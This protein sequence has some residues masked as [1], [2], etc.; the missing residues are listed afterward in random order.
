MRRRFLA[1]VCGP[2]VVV[3][4]GAVAVPA[5][6]QVPVSS[7]ATGTSE[8]AQAPASSQT[9]TQPPAQEAQPA[10]PKGPLAE[11]SRS[12]FAPSWNM[13]QL[14]GRVSSIS[15]DEARWQR[16]EDLGDGL[17]FTTGRLLRETPEWS[18]TAGADNVGW[19]DQRYFGNYERIG[20]LKVSGLWDQ[21]PQFY[22]IDTRTA[23]TS[24]G[25]GVLVLDDNAQR[26]ANLNTYL[27]ISP[28][29]DLREQRDIGTVRVGATPTTHFDV[30]GGFTTTKHSGELPW[31]S[32]FGFGNDNEVAL[33]YRSRT[34][35][36]DFGA[37]W[38][39]S[40]AMIRAAYSGS[41]FENQDDT[42]VWDNPLV[43]TD[44]TT[45]PGR[46]RTALW[47]SNSLQTL[48][49]AGYMKFTRRTQLTGSL[50]FGWWNN[51]EPLL[52][53]TINSA[54]PQMPLPRATAEAAAHTIATNLNFVSRPLD[55]WRFSAR[56]RLYD[57][58][59]ETPETSIPQFINYDTSVATSSTGGP[60]LYAHDRNTFDADA[61]WTGLGPV[62][63]T[64]GYTN[65]HYGYDH[66]IFQSTNENVLQLKA[67]AVGSQWVT[68]RAHYEYGSRSG[69]GLD[70]ASLVQIGEQPQM[71]HYD[72]ANRTQNR[73]I[74][75]V[76]VLPTE[77][78]TFSVSTSLGGNDF[79]DS[80]F[81]LQESTFRN[82]AF[83]F[84]YELPRGIGVGATY[85][86]ERYSGQ[87]QSRSASP[88]EQAADPNRN[89]AVDTR[90]TVHYVSVFVQP[91]RIGRNTEARFSYDYAHA[92]GNFVYAVGPALPPPSQLPQTFNKLQDLR[93][94]VR[95]RLSGRLAAT[96]SYVYEPYR[97]YD[98]AFDPTVINSIVQ[99]SSLILGYQYRP[100]TANWV[101]FGVLYYW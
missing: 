77:R 18:V 30:S 6:A 3:L 66:R 88:G 70:E 19:H 43:L 84:D 28:Q 87:Q 92:R 36:M 17:L 46:G 68:F 32:D 61:T 78:L 60:E 74:G 63:L 52:P 96:L 45:A 29:F 49:T 82:V 31:G 48:S 20:K 72:L 9:A 40:K 69:S 56:Y 58:N 4:V 71:R 25:E 33:P 90:E 86:Y 2:L 76:D 95:Y 39:N 62:A 53:F 100:Y 83:S 16:Y 91:P 22:S 75:Q 65:Y 12:L 81:G 98:F 89:W 59:N 24:G 47:P 55:D 8:R 93:F 51:D 23:F 37:Q 21:I 94:D 73:F 7:T 11:D 42:L 79:D 14:S 64:V 13:F 26:A 41:W 80:Y 35:D 44:S 99:P 15:G 10:A 5:G 50:A 1:H 34:N 27:S 101:V 67:D 54:L 85:N 97:I 38:T 57:Y